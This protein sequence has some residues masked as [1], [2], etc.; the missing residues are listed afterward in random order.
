[1]EPTSGPRVRGTGVL[2]TGR[3]LLRGDAGDA[4]ID[5]DQAVQFRRRYPDWG[6]WGLS[7][8]GAADPPAL[9]AVRVERLGR[10]RIV[11]ILDPAQLISLG[12]SVVPTFRAPQV[13][14]AWSGSLDRGLSD[15]LD[16]G[17]GWNDEPYHEPGTDAWR[18]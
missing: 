11:W 15:L 1:M 16:A 9:R 12:F 5:R 2:P 14:V 13:T 3:L 4:S 8:F 7:F 10:F 6:R 18:T 17:R